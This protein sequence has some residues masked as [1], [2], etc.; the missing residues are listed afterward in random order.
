MYCTRS[1]VVDEANGCEGSPGLRGHLRGTWWTVMSRGTWPQGLAAS[2][3]L[4]LL[5]HV[6]KQMI[7][8]CEVPVQ[9]IPPHLISVISIL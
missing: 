8:V 3:A 1:Q 2:P 7:D 4:S 5:P 9:A 6:F